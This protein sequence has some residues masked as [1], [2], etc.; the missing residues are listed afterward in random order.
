[1]FLSNQAAPGPTWRRLVNEYY[2]RFA[3][4]LSVAPGDASPRIELT[5]E[6]WRR[7]G[8]LEQYFFAQAEAVLTNIHDDQEMN[9]FESLCRR[10]MT[11]I[12]DAKGK[13]ASL[14]TINNLCG[15]GTRAAE[16]REVCRGAKSCRNSN[17]VARFVP[18]SATGRPF[19]S[20]SDLRFP[21]SRAG[22]YL[23]LAAPG[24][25][26]RFPLRLPKSYRLTQ[27]SRALSPK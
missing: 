13:G 4:L 12:G 9:R 17:R 8:I 27:C 6:A 1:M 21:A 15:L 7:A 14:S 3:T 24:L 18:T 26:L 22:S 16:R 2:P 25:R 5:P 23:I 11:I 19:S 10:I 20:P